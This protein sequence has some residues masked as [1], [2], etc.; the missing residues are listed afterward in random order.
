MKKTGSENINMV[1]EEEMNP[2]AKNPFIVLAC[3]S[4]F[5]S[6]YLIGKTVISLIG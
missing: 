2:M 6:M 1:A 3:L 4:F 5:P